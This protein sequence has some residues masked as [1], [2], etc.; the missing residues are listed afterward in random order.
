[1]EETGA[2]ISRTGLWRFRMKWLTIGFVT[3]FV[4]VAI[5]AV[6]LANGPR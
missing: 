4:G 5:A 2:P 3:P 1:M 6:A